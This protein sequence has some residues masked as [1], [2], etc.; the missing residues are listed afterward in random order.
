MVSLF[1]TQT[2]DDSYICILKR[3]YETCMLFRR[4]WTFR[5]AIY[6]SLIGLPE[7]PTPTSATLTSSTLI[8]AL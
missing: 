5:D 8:D 4:R 2:I 1:V 6:S 3:A 7:I